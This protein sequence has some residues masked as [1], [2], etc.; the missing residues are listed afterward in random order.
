MKITYVRTAVFETYVRD[1]WDLEI[2]QE[3][4]DLIVSG[5]HPDY[6]DLEDWARESSWCAGITASRSTEE[7]GDFKDEDEEISK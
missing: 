3:E 6:D 1:E 7:A 4:H 2:S 5:E